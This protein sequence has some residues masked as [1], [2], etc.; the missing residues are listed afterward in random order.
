MT[1]KND[2]AVLIVLFITLAI[3]FPAIAI[4]VLQS[5]LLIVGI[6]IGLVIIILLIFLFLK[7]REENTSI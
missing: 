7:M 2:W 3:V 5:V 1:Q 6:A 4:Y